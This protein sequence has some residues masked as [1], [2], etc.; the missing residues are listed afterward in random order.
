MPHGEWVG[1]RLN[2]FAH[3]T[4]PAREEGGPAEDVGGPRQPAA[5][6]ASSASSRRTPTGSPAQYAEMGEA[7]GRQAV[8]ATS[9]PTQRRLGAQGPHAA[10]AASWSPARSRSR[11]PS[12][13]TRREQMKQQGRADRLVR[14]RAGD[15]ARQRHRRGDEGA[16]SARGGALPRFRAVP[17]GPEDP[18]RA[19]LRPDQQEG[20]HAPQQ[21]PDE[22]RRP[23]RCWTSSK[24]E[25]LYGEIFGERGA[26]K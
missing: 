11:S 12:T 17:R 8:P 16:A 25:K 1:T 21:D 6:R 22:V 3:A 14:H 19:R 2:V 15:R 13:T 9:S 23:A 26:S 24:W 4:T 18:R 20:R 5:G 10:H 7:Q